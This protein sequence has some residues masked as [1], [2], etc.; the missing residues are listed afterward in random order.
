MRQE[1]RGYIAV[2]VRSG[3][4]LRT[5]KAVRIRC[6]TKFQVTIDLDV[7]PAIQVLLPIT[8]LHSVYTPSTLLIVADG[9]SRTM[10]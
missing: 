10:C 3:D 8:F 7:E 2:P 4:L 5:V 9:Q 6:L 1:L